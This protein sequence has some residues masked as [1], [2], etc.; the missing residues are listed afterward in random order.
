MLQL[1]IFLAETESVLI[2]RPFVYIREELIQGTTITP[3]HFLLPNM[4]ERTPQL[5]TEEGIKDSDYQEKASSNET[6]LN[7]WKKGQDILESFWEMWR[8]DNLL[9]L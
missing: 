2:L 8:N 7:T 6:L 1:Q 5:G 9:N 3:T 4:K